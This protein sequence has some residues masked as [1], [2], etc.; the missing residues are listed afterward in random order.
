MP[1]TGASQGSRSITLSEGELRELTGYK[2]PADQ[3]RDLH[4]PGFYR[5]RRSPTAGRSLLERTHHDVV[6]SGDT[7]NNAPSRARPKLCCWISVTPTCAYCN[8]L[9]FK[10]VENASRLSLEKCEGCHG[11]GIRPLEREVPHQ[12]REHARWLADQLDKRVLVIHDRV[13]R[14]LSMRME[15][16]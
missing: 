13:S 10:E 12:H 2:R 1:M 7:A 16:E 5:A 3:L 4:P 15:F 14:L 11:K 9:G 6:S 8:D